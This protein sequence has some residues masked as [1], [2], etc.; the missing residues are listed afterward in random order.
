MRILVTGGAGFIGSHL[1]K[2]L[3]KLGHKVVVV[4]NFNDYYDIK[5]KEDRIRIFLKGL[6]LKV[7]RIDIADYKK[8][9][10]VFK[11]NKFDKVIHLAAQAG[12]RYSLTH[13][14][15]YIN[16][17]I[18]G[19]VNLLELVKDYKIKDFI[20]ASS[21]SVYGGNKKIPFAEKDRVDKPVSLYAATKKAGELICFNYH[22]LY[23]INCIC[24][25][26]FTVYGPWGR[27]DMALFKFTRNI[28][29]G[30]PI[31]V[32]NYGRMA[33]DFTYIDDIIDGIVATLDKNF[34][35]EIFNL[36]N[37]HPEKLGDFISLVEKQTGK[38]AVQTKMPMQMGDVK[39]T[40]ADIKKAGKILAYKPKVRI[41]EGI[42]K[43][44]EWYKEY[45]N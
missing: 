2:R 32:Y 39:A 45:Y 42:G 20:F 17:N 40:W 30:R 44:I 3:I 7:Y 12:V 14:F 29:L 23:N 15:V 6:K 8:L 26:F 13:P 27:P 38:K 37:S 1:V 21:S 10:T 16:S 35:Y 4:D 33:R 36:G 34:S 19:T 24:L 28:L 5:L 41:G 11:K 43:F 25:R 31:E 9:A 22:H 18:Q